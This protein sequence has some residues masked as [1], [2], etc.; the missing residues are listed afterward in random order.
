MKILADRPNSEALVNAEKFT[1]DLFPSLVGTRR[2]RSN[3]SAIQEN[4]HDAWVDL[5]AN[6]HSLFE[7]AMAFRLRLQLNILDR[8]EFFW[9]PPNIDFD[10]KRMDAERNTDQKSEHGRILITL[11]P[12]IIVYPVESFKNPDG[13]LLNSGSKSG[14]VLAKAWVLLRS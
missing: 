8:H 11:F 2:T 6:V 3:E 9:P 12:G 13:L 4:D 10:D 7:R 1:D 5:R 14:E